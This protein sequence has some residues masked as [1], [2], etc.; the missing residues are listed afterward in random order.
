MYPYPQR[1]PS[2]IRLAPVV[3][4]LLVIAAAIALCG[5]FSLGY[6]IGVTPART[7][8]PASV[9]TTAQQ[10][11][12]TQAT[13]TKATA[14]PSNVVLSV[15]GNGEKTTAAFT[16]RGAWELSWTCHDGAHDFAVEIYNTAPDAVG[17]DEVSYTCPDSGIGSD[18]S[19]YHNGGTYYLDIISNVYWT[20]TVIDLPN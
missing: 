19:I 20:V 15:S 17:G 13:T 16:V 18:S 6:A 3:I 14:T 12:I 5:S 4:V 11:P 8:T 10:P 2:G 9:P 7:P 1:P